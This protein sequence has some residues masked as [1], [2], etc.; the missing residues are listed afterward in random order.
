E[1]EVTDMRI[2][3]F[4][5]RQTEN[6]RKQDNN[7]QLQQQHQN[8]R[9]NAGRAYAA[10]TVEKK[11]YGGSKPICS[12]CNYHHDGPCTPKCHK[13]N[14]VG[15]FARDCRSTA[16]ANNANNQKGTRS[17]QNPTCFECGV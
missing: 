1:I 9:Q 13:C 7:Q 6:K 4:T 12:K 8:K 17:G 3:T 5:D 14:K 11:Q 16:N 10:G 2:Y 15:H